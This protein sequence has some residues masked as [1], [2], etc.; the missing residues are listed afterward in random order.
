M[1]EDETGDS[2]YHNKSYSRP[3][4]KIIKGVPLQHNIEVVHVANCQ[5]TISI[6]KNS[7]NMNINRKAKLYK[8]NST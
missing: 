8:R 6:Q 7:N 3:K 5:Q 2:G 4:K 1:R